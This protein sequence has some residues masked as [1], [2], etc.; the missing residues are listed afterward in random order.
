M[1]PENYLLYLQIILFLFITPGSP[2]VLI[3]SYS[4]TYGVKKSAWVAFGDIT[5]NSIQMIVVTFII[6]SVLLA[7]PQIMI[8]MKWLGVIYLTYLAYELFRSKVKNFSSSNEKIAKTN[9]SFFRDGFLVAGLSP[10]ALIFF[11]AIFPN[12]INFEG[13]YISQ[14][15]ILAIT[16][17]VLDFITLMI[18]GLGAQKISIWLQANPKT[19]NIVSAAALLIIAFITGFVRF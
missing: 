14:F 11:G 2:R 8:I 13:N 17:V 1:Y 15:I 19:I 9:I 18:Y 4:M 3:V 10:K 7:Y 16:Y 6:G 5:A 12:F